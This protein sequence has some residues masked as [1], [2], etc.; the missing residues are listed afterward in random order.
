M[1]HQLINL[2]KKAIANLQQ[3]G[4]LPA[5]ITTNIQID[6]PRDKQHGDFATNIALILAKQVQAK[7]R[8][9]AEKIIANLPSEELVAKTEIAGPGFINFFLA[10]TAWS[11]V[12]K[13]ILSSKEKVGRS[14][15]GVGKRIHLEFVSSNPTG[16]LHVGHGRSAAY[17]ASLANIL[18]A[19]GFVVHREYYVNDAGR[20]MDIL[21]TSI[22]LRYLQQCGEKF[23]FPVNAYQ[24]DYV[25]EIARQLPQDKKLHQPVAEVYKDV[26]PD[27]NQGGDK[28]KH[29]DAL[30]ARAKDL[31]GKENYQKVFQ[32]GATT[33]LNDIRDDLAE[34]GVHF[35]EWFSE[36]SLIDNNTAQR[37]IDQL[38]ESNHLYQRDGALWFNS[39]AFGDDKDRVVLREN[40]QPT[41]FATDA[42][43]RLNILERGFDQLINVLGADHHGYI[44]R[45]R[46][47]IQALGRDPN[48]LVVPLVQFVAL[49]R[50]KERVAMSSRSGTFVTLRELR[51][52]VGNDAA[53]FF[54]VM[55]KCE[56]HMDF[57]LELAKS[58]SSDNPVYYIQYAHARICSVLR[59]LADRKLSWD[60]SEGLNALTLLKETH[61]TTLLQELSRYTEVVQS[62][63]LQHEPHLIANYLRD[64]AH[65]FHTY[66]NAHPFIVEHSELR[67]G[68]LSLIIATRYVIANGLSLLGV[69]APE[70]M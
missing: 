67:N 68:R 52:E 53:R 1:K 51:K 33:I 34:F 36:K 61:E 39:S 13:D 31:L 6:Y 23:T 55:R 17:G 42:A 60:E 5:E 44:P 57:D 45:I 11:Q 29:I 4:E 21:A 20:Q 43:Y 50:G 25:V 35:Q 30:I 59:Q 49:Y 58:Q 16:P 19:V 41:Y 26:P 3:K 2:I 65:A 66:Y 69:S 10:P 46:A 27:E 63:A 48:V 14:N 64:L 28:E 22:W 24:G 9:L 40:N 8:E 38:R 32:L 54:Y 18:E 37:T 7:P 62:A 15:M 56:Q 12:V 47:V 70:T